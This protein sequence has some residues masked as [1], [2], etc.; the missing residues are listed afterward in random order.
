MASREI[1]GERGR[2][3]WPWA[4]LLVALALLGWWAVERQGGAS[5]HD[6]PP[7]IMTSDAVASDAT[8]ADAVGPRAP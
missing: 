7:V 6:E 4:F 2:G 8:A 1:D 5:P 3:M